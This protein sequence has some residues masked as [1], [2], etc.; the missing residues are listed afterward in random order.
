MLIILKINSALFIACL[1]CISALFSPVVHAE[2]VIGNI[3]CG[4]WLENR[5]GELTNIQVSDM[6]WLGGYLSGLNTGWSV[7][8]PEILNDPLSELESLSQALLWMDNY[9]KAHPL[10][11]A[12][13]GGQELFFELVKRKKK[14]SK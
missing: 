12:S 2:R 8:A 4:K 7:S 6:S 5:K 11:T 10:E 9:C 1:V 14:S 3:D 13:K